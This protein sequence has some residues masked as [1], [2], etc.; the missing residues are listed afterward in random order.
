[1]ATRSFRGES[2]KLGARAWIDAT[3]V[4]IGRVTL[5]DDASVW[6]LAVVRG[7]VNPI[8]IGARSNVQ[9]GCVLHVVDEGPYTAGG[10]P[11]LIG[12]DVTI[13]HKAI[14]HAAHVGHRCLIGMGAVVLDGAVIEDEVIV[15]AGCLV[16]PGK[17]LYTR[18]LY[19]GNPAKRVRD[20]TDQDAAQLLYSA[21]HY[22]RIKDEYAGPPG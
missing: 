3:A 11:L 13:G 9:D 20:L 14:V 7:D 12:D 17:R 22:V 5:G 4:V 19:V 16:G 18:G 10:L 2:P 15:G 21:Q 6:P 1:M 8:Q